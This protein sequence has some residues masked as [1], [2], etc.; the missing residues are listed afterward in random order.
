MMEQWEREKITG[1]E[2]MV[3]LN[4]PVVLKS[5]LFGG[6]LCSYIL[7]GI[8]NDKSLRFSILVTLGIY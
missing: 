5:Q 2:K 4:L 6:F 7:P 1:Q 8:L 3:T